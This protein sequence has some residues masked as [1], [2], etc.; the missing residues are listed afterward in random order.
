MTK[1]PGCSL[2]LQEVLKVSNEVFMH[3]VQTFI[4][5]VNLVT[6]GR[7]IH[8]FQNTG[9]NAGLSRT[10]SME[11]CTDSK[12]YPMD[13]LVVPWKY[14]TFIGSTVSLFDTKNSHLLKEM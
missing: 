9:S 14:S 10:G 2:P 11:G 5:K 8:P 13:L 3:K 7:R 6:A 12:Q 4:C 1:F